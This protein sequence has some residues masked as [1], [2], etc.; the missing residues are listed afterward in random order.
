MLSDQVV[1]AMG[2]MVVGT[3]SGDASATWPTLWCLPGM[4]YPLAEGVPLACEVEV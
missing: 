1:T 2:E 3:P 4:R